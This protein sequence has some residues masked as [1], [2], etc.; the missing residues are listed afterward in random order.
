MG[1]IIISG[2]WHIK[3]GI[4]TSLAIDFLDY[5]YLYYKENKINL[6]IVAGDIFDKSS[7]IKNESFIPVYKKLWE[8][9]NNG[10]KFIFILGNHDIINVDNNSIIETFEPI[11]KVVKEEEEITFNDIKITL[12]PYTKDENKIPKSGD[13]LVTHLPIA[14]FSFDNSYHVT[15]KHAFKRSLFEE[16]NLVLTNHFHRHQHRKNIVYVGSPYQMNRGERGHDKGFVIFDTETENWEFIKYEGA[17]TYLQINTEDIKSLNNFEFKN[18][19]VVVKMDRKIKDFAKL[20][21]ILYDMGA[22]DVIPLFESVQ[23]DGN[24]IQK[25]VEVNENIGEMIKVYI[26]K[27]ELENIDNN[28]LLKLFDRVLKES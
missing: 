22:V 16:F 25:E 3:K 28:K 15:E 19:F 4:Y 11:G 20:K 10:V 17:P 6:F 27:C 9:K 26:T 2:D 12:L 24:E 8:M 14:D 13:V 1:K 18:S 21:Y 23:E 7:N 5:A